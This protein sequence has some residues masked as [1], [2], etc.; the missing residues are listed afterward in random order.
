MAQQRGDK[1]DNVRLSPSILSYDFGNLRGTI[2]KL[3]KCNIDSIH[4]DVMDGHFVR[5]ITIGPMVIS[6]IRNATK[7]ITQFRLPIRQNGD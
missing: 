1:M 3:D 4:I 7:T 6:A 5:N 2:R